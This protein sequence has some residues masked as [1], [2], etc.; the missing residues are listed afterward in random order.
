[1]MQFLDRAAISYQV[2]LTKADQIKAL[3]REAKL[4]QVT[5]IL[6][7][8]PAA[9]EEALMTSSDKGAGIPEFRSLLAF[10]AG[11]PA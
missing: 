5:A 11:A 6:N 7:K 8:H 4:R 10:F 3:D 9:R 1:M 2:A